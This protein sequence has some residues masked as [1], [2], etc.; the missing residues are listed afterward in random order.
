MRKVEVEAFDREKHDV[1]PQEGWFHCWGVEFEEF[2]SGPANTTVAIVE[3]VKDHR[4]VTINPNQ[5]RFLDDP[6]IVK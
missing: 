2:E 6:E 3:L 4:V 1:V 5:V